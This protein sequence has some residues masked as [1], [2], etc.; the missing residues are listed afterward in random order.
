MQ[1]PSVS[2]NLEKTA[3]SPRIQLQL[4][5]ASAHLSLWK[6]AWKH[7]HSSINW[8]DWTI[9][10]MLLRK[11]LGWFGTNLLPYGQW[12]GLEMYSKQFQG[13]FNFT[14]YVHQP[15][16]AIHLNPPLTIKLEGLSYSNPS[17]ND[18][19]V[20]WSLF[21]QLHSGVRNPTSLW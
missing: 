17:P 10:F 2:L 9:S 21:G 19:Q 11:Y 1:L 6:L 13:L 12:K 3:A 15:N 5:S 8:C 16:Y 4:C 7:L 14:S 20:V 18:T